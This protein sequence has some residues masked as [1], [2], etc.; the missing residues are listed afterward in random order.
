MNRKGKYKPAS[1][2]FMALSDIEV[3]KLL[4][5]FSQAEIAKQYGLTAS[6]ISLLQRK[7]NL[8]PIKDLNRTRKVEFTPT[9]FLD[10][11][12]E[13]DL[14]TTDSWINSKERYSYVNAGLLTNKSLNYEL[15]L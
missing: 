4:T 15:P 9:R 10:N 2:K 5:I 13:S 14:V 7:R 11:R 3:I 1:V 6:Q 8:F 12:K